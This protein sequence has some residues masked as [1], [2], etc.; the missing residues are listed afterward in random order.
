MKS[1]DSIFIAWIRESGYS[2]SRR[3]HGVQRVQK[4]DDVKRRRREV[5]VDD[6]SLTR[7]P[8]G[9]CGDTLCT[10]LRERDV[11]EKR[12]GGQACGLRH[13]LRKKKPVLR[14]QMLHRKSTRGIK[15]QRQGE[16]Q[17]I[18]GRILIGNIHHTR[19]AGD[20]QLVDLLTREAVARGRALPRTVATPLYDCHD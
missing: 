1:S 15:P 16:R 7:A 20:V 11:E 9:D 19:P 12:G 4:N 14:S 17:L 6:R 8:L 3:C 5:R 2:S 10:R 13:R 18:I